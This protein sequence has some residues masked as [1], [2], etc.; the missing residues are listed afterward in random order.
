MYRNS[1]AIKAL[2]F[3]G[4]IAAVAFLEDLGMPRGVP[5]ERISTRVGVVRV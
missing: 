2:W 3:Q 1:R 5:W 4:T